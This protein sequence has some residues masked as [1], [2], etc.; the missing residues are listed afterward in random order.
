MIGCVLLASG[1]S[2]RF[3]NENKLLTPLEGATLAERA[4]DALP[5]DLF[6]PAVVVSQYP[7][8][9]T[10]AAQRGY[11]AVENP[12][13]AEGVSS[14][15]RLGL[16]ACG[17]VDGILFSVCDQ[18]WLT[19]GSVRRLVE[20]WRAQPDAIAALSVH[21]IRGNPVLFPRRHFP[22]LAALTGDRGG[23]AVLHAHPEELLLVEA[24]H[25]RELEDVDYPIK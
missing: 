24:H 19:A 13:A 22:A 8:L 3:G 6:H 11:L 16:A 2:R 10:L 15:I 5:P 25:P 12:G 18:P 9:L 14:S 4:M 1:L 7:E 20:A 23:S 17:D 21:G